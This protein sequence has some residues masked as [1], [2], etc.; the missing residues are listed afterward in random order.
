[1]PLVSVR[2]TPPA[3][4]AVLRRLAPSAKGLQTATWSPAAY[5]SPSLGGAGNVPDGAYQSRT[6][7]FGVVCPPR[8]VT[9]S[10]VWSVQLT[11]R[12]QATAGVYEPPS[13]VGWPAASGAY[14]TTMY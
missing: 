10:G 8:T 1:M 11:L 4:P 7:T 14:A 9:C 12:P 2:S 5:G 3:V 6:S 13:P